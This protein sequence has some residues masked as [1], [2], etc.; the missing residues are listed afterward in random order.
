[1]KNK[2]LAIIIFVGILLAVN[3]TLT[4]CGNSNEKTEEETT[5]NNIINEVNVEEIYF[6]VLDE[7]RS[8][9]TKNGSEEYISDYAKELISDG[10]LAVS[11][12][13]LNMDIDSQND[14]EMVVLLESSGDGKYLILNYEDDGLVYGFK[15]EYREMLNLKADGTYKISGGAAD[16]K[17]IKS[18]FNKNQIFDNI[19]AGVE[20]GEYTF[21]NNSLNSKEDFEKYMKEFDSKEPV[22]FTLY[23]EISVEDDT[24]SSNNQTDNTNVNSSEISKEIEG[25]FRVNFSE[26]IEREM[27]KLY[28]FKIGKWKS[29]I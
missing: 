2:T 14:K 5:Q 18:T 28:D 11:Y 3:I 1:M 25:T 17:I 19:V 15:K 21:N 22:K 10:N 27:R 9:I 8:Y 6:Q 7:Q 20:N 23:K 26:D 24:S 29:N 13:I 4:G 16:T 12:A